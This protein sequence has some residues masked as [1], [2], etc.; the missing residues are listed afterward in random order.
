MN[1]MLGKIKCLTL[2]SVLLTMF[3]Y[4]LFRNSLAS[5]SNWAKFCLILLVSFALIELNWINTALQRRLLIKLFT[6]SLSDRAS[7]KMNNKNELNLHESKLK[8]HRI[9]QK[10]ILYSKNLRL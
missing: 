6:N 1:R 9:L 3:E 10:I 2:S 4:N 8:A 5:L 7:I